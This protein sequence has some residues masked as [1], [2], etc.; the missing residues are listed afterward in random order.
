MHP[1]LLP[2]LLDFVCWDGPFLSLEEMVLEHQPDLQVS[3][4][5]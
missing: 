1:A 2:P 3:S 4:S 5:L